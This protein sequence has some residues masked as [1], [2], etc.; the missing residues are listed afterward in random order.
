ML[1][2]FQQFGIAIENIPK[3]ASLFYFRDID[4]FIGEGIAI[5]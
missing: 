2:V 1:I 3:T 4:L 5:T